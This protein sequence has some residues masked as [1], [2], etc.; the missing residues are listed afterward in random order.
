MNFI[1][2][3]GVGEI[4]CKNYAVNRILLEPGGERNILLKTML[5]TFIGTR[6][7]VFNSGK[8]HSYY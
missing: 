6:W 7:R 5:L 2:T 8:N 3:R 4:F 1:G